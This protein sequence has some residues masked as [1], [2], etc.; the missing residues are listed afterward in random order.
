[1]QKLKEIIFNI[2][3]NKYEDIGLLFED[4]VNKDK[5]LKDLHDIKERYLNSA[6]QFKE[7]LLFVN[8][9]GIPGAGKTTYCEKKIKAGEKF[10]YISF[11]KI[12]E[13]MFFYQEDVNKD[14]KKAFS[15]WELPARIL[16]Y[17][18]LVNLINLKCPILFEHS[19][20]NLMHLEL[21]KYLKEQCGYKV[22]MHFVPISVG[23]ACLRV[24]K[25][26]AITK[27]HTPTT[28]IIKRS[29]VLKD[30]IPKYKK[31]VDVFKNA[32]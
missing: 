27:R 28:F 5:I 32:G 2:T 3:K 1:M 11:D 26:E 24:E 6:T 31:I 22:E 17:E 30:L 16:G 25:R 21:F 12:M 14:S 23:E 20:A 9:S 19:S 29:E 8:V 7:N 18:I 10:I 15:R 13:E 4:D